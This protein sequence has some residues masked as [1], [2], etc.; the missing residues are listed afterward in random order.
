[1]PERTQQKQYNE[2][3]IN[4]CIGHVLS[5]F[6]EKPEKDYKRSFNRNNGDQ[7]TKNQIPHINQSS[8]FPPASL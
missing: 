3:H 1:M 6:M 2:H 5:P 4:H 7:P 8:K